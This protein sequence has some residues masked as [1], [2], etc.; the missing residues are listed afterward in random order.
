MDPSAMYP[1]AQALLDYFNGDHS[2]VFLIRRDD[3]LESVEELDAFFREGDAFSAIDRA[4]LELCRGQV[5]DIGAGAGNH[6]LA[7]QARGLD[8]TSLDIAPQAVE[9]MQRRGVRRA[10][11]ASID[12]YQ[13]GPFDT[14]LLMMHGIGLVETLAGL[15]RLLGKM[16]TL[17]RPG[18][19]VLLDSLDVTRTDDPV[20]LA[21]HDANR[22]AGRY[23]GEIRNAFGYRGGWGPLCGWLHV[24]AQTLGEHARR[25]G[26]SLEVIR[27]EEN[28]DYLACLRIV[29][30]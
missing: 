16:K 6:S 20:H 9:V 11:C 19:Q 2:A 21:Y 28:G 30:S 4:A 15:D 5:L 8:V 17:V 25:A 24:D 10:L 12:D 3:G 14:A 29:N 22:A 26:W 27:Q 7:L 23:V 1:Y 18:G 13:G